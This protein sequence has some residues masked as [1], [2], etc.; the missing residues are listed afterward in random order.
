[1]TFFLTQIFFA[2]VLTQ[3]PD[4]YA[5]TEK[6][7]ELPP[8]S[9]EKLKWIAIL[10]ICLPFWACKKINDNDIVSFFHTSTYSY[11]L[12]EEAHQWFK[13]QKETFQSSSL[14]NSR[15]TRFQIL[16]NIKWE[17]ARTYK[18]IGKYVVEA[19]VEMTYNNKNLF[20]Q[21]NSSDKAIK[22]NFNKGITRAV[23]F[24][25]RNG[26]GFDLYL[27]LAIGKENYYAKYPNQIQYNQQN[28]W[29]KDFS[30]WILFFDWQEVFLN[31]Y[32]LYEGRIV[33]IAKGKRER[34]F[35]ETQ[36][37]QKDGCHQVW[38]HLGW[39]C[40]YDNPDDPSYTPPPNQPNLPNLPPSNNNPNPPQII[41]KEFERQ[42]IC[43]ELG[44]WYTECWTF[45][46][47]GGGGGSGGSGSNT[48]NLPNNP[49]H[50]YIPPIYPDPSMDCQGCWESFPQN[51]SEVCEII[52]G[53]DYGMP[54]VSY[55]LLS[56]TKNFG[57]LTQELASELDITLHSLI[58]NSPILKKMYDYLVQK[59]VK[60]SWKYGTGSSGTGGGYNPFTKEISLYYFTFLL[61]GR[62][63]SRFPRCLLRRHLPC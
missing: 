61:S 42:I 35:I 18:H 59:K 47:Y 43:Q 24:K 16:K 53:S 60:I 1:L 31:G 20:Y 23:M 49:P 3:T 6:I 52:C 17:T 44:Y 34:D 11:A 46:P 30:G 62:V 14:L 8:P 57:N 22:N 56:I 4:F 10:G 38:V 39:D 63:I 29:D 27:M 7:N 21:I 26:V 50:P 13:N 40:Y 41:T 36:S 58:D 5:K 12:I 32:E 45:P 37:H 25:Q 15:N 48:P 19:D 28:K 33:R 51:A 2:P 9:L 54:I 55:E